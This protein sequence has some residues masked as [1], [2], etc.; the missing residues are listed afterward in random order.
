MMRRC[1]ASRDQ[2]RLRG[3]RPPRGHPKSPADAQAAPSQVS[4]GAFVERATLVVKTATHDHQHAGKELQIDERLQLS[5]ERAHRYLP[6]SEIIAVLLLAMTFIWL[7]I[8]RLRRFWTPQ[9]NTGDGAPSDAS[10][11]VLVAGETEKMTPVVQKLMHV[12][13]LD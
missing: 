10:G 6:L 7:C 11:R 12:H 13:S 8:K 9:F 2:S 3:L 4:I 5:Q 1:S